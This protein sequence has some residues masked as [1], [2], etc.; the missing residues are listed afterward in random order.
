MAKFWAKVDKRGPDEC[1]PWTGGLEWDGYPR[2]KTTYEGE[3]FGR[4][5]RFAYR[6]LVGPI[7]EGYT[8]DHLC[9]TEECKLKEA[10]CPHRRCCNPAHLLA[11]TNRDNILRGN[12]IARE[13][14]QKTKC[15]KG[16]P[17]SGDNLY[18]SPAGR[19]C[20]RTCERA[21]H[22]RRN[23]ALKEERRRRRA[24][25]CGES[26]LILPDL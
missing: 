15:R 22:E 2:F 9:H 20:C 17:L 25:P 16:H 14:S 18:V 3:R 7:P 11:A 5:H 13:N 10:D 24:T 1:W 6:A 12:G 23:Q 19:R 21:K 26:P 8:I 4:A